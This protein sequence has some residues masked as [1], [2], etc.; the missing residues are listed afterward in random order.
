MKLAFEIKI[1]F[2]FNLNSANKIL[3]LKTSF[4]GKTLSFHLEVK[5]INVPNRKSRF[6]DLNLNT[7]Y[8]AHDSE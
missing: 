3:V 7:Y 5:K 2:S 1:L 6:D 8:Q 4:I